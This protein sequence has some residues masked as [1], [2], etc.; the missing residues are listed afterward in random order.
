MIHRLQLNS[1]D[2]NIDVYKKLPTTEPN[3]KYVIRVEGLTLP[4]TTDGLILNK[5]LFDVRRRLIVGSEPDNLLTDDVLPIR[6]GVGFGAMVFT[7]NDVRSYP[8][9]VYQMN[10]FFRNR[11]LR[12]LFTQPNGSNLRTEDDDD[13][14]FDRPD[15]FKTQDEGD[16]YSDLINSDAALPM[17]NALQAIYRSDGRLAI[18]FSRSAQELFVLKL[19]DEGKRI[20]GLTTND[21]VDLDYVAVNA[22]GTFAEPYL[23][24]GPPPFFEPEVLLDLPAGTESRICV[25]KNN[26]FSH[27]RYRHEVAV[28]SSLPLNA[29]VEVDQRN[30]FYK[31][32]LAS[33]R[34]PNYPMETEFDNTMFRNL[35][36]VRR[37]RYTFENAH[38][39]H[40]EFYLSG[41]DLQNFHIR[42]VSRNYVWD[43]SLNRFEITERPYK[44]HEGQLWTLTLTVKPL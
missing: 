25:F 16:W 27:G 2:A 20:F 44:L 38:K 11:M 35:K 24:H 17:Q 13:D 18:K 10:A 32:Q 33:Y 29:F 12:L 31:Y 6:E 28:L 37:S 8:Q 1:R 34:Y 15:E 14:V 7:P 43:N 42:L 19:T 23:A 9:L 36:E 26:I 41:T 4:E 40:N 21:G 30:S 22:N 5:P 39:T 3:K